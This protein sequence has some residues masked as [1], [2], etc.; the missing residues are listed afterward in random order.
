MRL[1]VKQDGYL[2]R[3][4]ADYDEYEVNCVEDDED[5][6]NDDDDQD[7]GIDLGGEYLSPSFGAGEAAEYSATLEELMD[8][9]ADADADPTNTDEEV[10]DDDVSKV[11]S[12]VRIVVGSWRNERVSAV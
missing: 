9:T 7:V 5:D 6:N 1:Q 2:N 12:T 10:E 4:T 11:K 8:F 3:S